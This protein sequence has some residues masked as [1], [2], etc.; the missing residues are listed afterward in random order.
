M[1]TKK[2]VKNLGLI[3]CLICWG[4]LTPVQ[5]RGADLSALLM[6]KLGVTQPQAE[7]GSGALFK[8]AKQ[9]LSQ[10][11]FKRVAKTVPGID[12]LMQAAPE[13]A[14]PKSGFGA[15]TSLFGKSSDS[16]GG[17]AGL[18]GSFNKLGLSSGM[19]GKFVPIILNYV[20]S[21]GGTQ[22]MNLL[23]GAWK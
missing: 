6:N 3:F 21:K 15:I 7:G 11:A 10:Q 1:P 4:V 16:V 9:K 19:V 5:A 17:M 14:K 2:V 8:L 13:S 18:A 12:A 20:E 22:V 23:K